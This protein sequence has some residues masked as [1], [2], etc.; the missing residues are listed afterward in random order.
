MLSPSCDFTVKWKESEKVRRRRRR[1]K[2][3]QE[4]DSD[5]K[6][7]DYWREGAFSVQL[8]IMPLL[9]GTHPPLTPPPFPDSSW[10]LSNVA[11]SPC[12]QQDTERLLA[13]R[14]QMLLSGHW[15]GL[16]QR[17]QRGNLLPPTD[18]MVDGDKLRMAVAQQA[19]CVLV[20]ARV[21]WDLLQNQRGYL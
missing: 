8:A 17:K 19:D 7:A 2:K 3:Y 4:E 13:W 21:A 11:K 12:S 9:A 16:Q 20:F 14:W 18:V 6:L 15:V 1:S 5:A 10:C